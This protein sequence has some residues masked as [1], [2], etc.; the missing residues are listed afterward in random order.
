MNRSLHKL[1]DTLSNRKETPYSGSS[2]I[3][4]SACSH[5]QIAKEAP[6]SG[7]SSIV[8]SGVLKNYLAKILVLLATAIINSMEQ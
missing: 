6:Y 1:F 7:S 8:A 5:C 4:A 2:G 3:V